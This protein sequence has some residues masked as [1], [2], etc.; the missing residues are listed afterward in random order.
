MLI[1]NSI[2]YKIKI[3]LKSETKVDSDYKMQ[4]VQ[5]FGRKKTAIAVASV[6]EAKEGCLQ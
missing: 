2:A 6:R 1:W 3:F 5:T 4:L